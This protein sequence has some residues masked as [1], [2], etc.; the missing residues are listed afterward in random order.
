ME[1]AASRGQPFFGWRI[2]W[3]VALAQALGPA[4]M[5]PI[6]VFMTQ[7]LDE[8]GASRAAV[9]LG[10]PIL[11]GMMMLVGLVVGPRLD[12]GP[13]RRIMLWGVVIM[14]GAMLGL[15]RGRSLLEV[16]ALLAVASV[17]M[18][19][20]G[21]LPAQVLLVNWFSRLRGQALALS[22]VGMSISGLT[23][24]PLCAWLIAQYGW[25]ESVS[26]IALVAALLCF[27]PI[28][29]FVINRPEDV[30][31]HPDGDTA[32][33]TP[34]PPS[35]RLSFRFFLRDANFWLVSVGMGLALSAL[36][37]ALHLVPFGQSLG[38]ELREAAWAPT[39]L[40]SGSLVGKLLGGWSIDR[41]GKRATVVGLLVIQAL[42]WVLL[43]SEPDYSTLLAGSA[44]MGFGA[45][46]F[47]PLPP[48]FLA[49]CFG[50]NVVGQA[51][52]LAGAA[53]LPIQMLAPPLV[54]AVFDS[55]GS[56]QIAFQSMVG[57]ALLAAVLL[58]RVRVPDRDL[59]PEAAP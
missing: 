56:Y 37:V 44:L 9:S 5:G 8:C 1:G 16:G 40:S 45:G 42:G 15:A 20:Y 58:I 55:T 38:F 51:S 22:T 53:A 41:L 36:A 18:S 21:T 7:L 24:P 52:G 46:G 49:A 43:A 32:S 34:A 17:G 57:V 10:G 25:R 4:L 26:Y 47:L 29:A 12:R 30:G 33:A 28:L 19:M 39:A 27:P 14:L 6:G 48:I 59:P 35:E 54:G 31:Q 13:I 2:V 23:L 50:R 11:A 3:T